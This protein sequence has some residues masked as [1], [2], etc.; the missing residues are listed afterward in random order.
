MRE[1]V[2]FGKTYKDIGSLHG[3]SKGAHIR[4]FGGK[5]ALLSVQICTIGGDDSLRVQHNEIALL[6]TEGE[7]KTRATN[8]SGS[9]SIDDNF[10][11][12]N[13]LSSYFASIEQTCARDDGSAVLVVV[14]HGDVEFILQAG[15][16]FKAFW[17]FDVF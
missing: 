14:H 9:S 15:F 13:A 16:N 4:A 11:V 2:A 12:F 10:Y 3:F 17:C 6:K 1:D 7:I 5:F 8:G